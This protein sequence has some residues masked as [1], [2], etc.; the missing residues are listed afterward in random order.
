V[1]TSSQVLKLDD[2][3]FAFQVYQSDFGGFVQDMLDSW[4]ANDLVFFTWNTG[5]APVDA[6]FVLV[7]PH[8]VLRF[9]VVLLGY[10]VPGAPEGGRM[11]FWTKSFVSDRPTLWKAPLEGTARERMS[12]L[13]LSQ[14][15]PRQTGV[16]K[17]SV[18]GKWYDKMRTRT[19]PQ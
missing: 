16:F 5:S 9:F 2:A 4:Q 10:G 19:Q 1:K 14:K 12:G 13:V 18:W 6:N 8:D 7:L 17:H 3:I 11:G 15:S